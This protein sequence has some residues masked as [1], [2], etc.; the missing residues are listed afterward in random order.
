MT[1]S[2]QEHWQSVY[3]RK[4]ETEVSWYEARPERA[5]ALLDRAGLA[6]HH[7]VID[8]G[9]GASHLVDALVAI[10]QA[11]VA[12]L[13]ISEAALATARSRLGSR[14]EAVEWIVSDIT[15]FVPDRTY[16]IWHDRA[17]FHFLTDP[18]E[19]SA[20][21]NVLTRALVPG[22]IAVIGTFAL[23]GPERC[24]GLPVARYDAQGIA[25]ALGPKLRLIDARHDIHT[26]PWGSEQAFQFA[27]LER[28]AD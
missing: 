17:A 1:K 5:L 3:T 6:P 16:D 25:D 28:L 4:G 9:G 13:D 14:A 18:G 26:T 12:V 24:S 27:V 20:Y 10:N 19:R 7:A 11:H 2:D 8:V 23:D 15:A 21:R 22:G